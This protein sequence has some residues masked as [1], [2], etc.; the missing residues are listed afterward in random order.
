MVYIEVIYIKTNEMGPGDPTTVPPADVTP[1]TGTCTP[2]WG[3]GCGKP[4]DGDGERVGGGRRE[5][6]RGVARPRMSTGNGGGKPE[7]E[8][9]GD[10]NSPAS[11]APPTTSAG[12]PATTKTTGTSS[13]SP[14]RGLHRWTVPVLLLRPALALVGTPEL[15]DD[16]VGSAVVAGGSPG[17]PLVKDEHEHDGVEQLP[18]G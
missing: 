6:I 13:R 2:G 11:T 3:E 14:R 4:A 12:Y 8:T 17:R 10:G 5:L 9:G 18:L 15:D 7:R 16:V 1:G